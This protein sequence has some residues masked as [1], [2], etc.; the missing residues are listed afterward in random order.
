MHIYDISLTITPRL[1]VWPGDP[2]IVLER[3]SRIEDGDNANVSR[4]AM[5]VHTGT[6]L[7]AP[8]HFLA[9]SS[10][11]VEQLD[12]EVLTGPA[13][14]IRLPDE[15]ELVTAKVLQ[16]ARIPAHTRRLLLKTRNSRFWEDP[17]AGFQTDF[18]ALRADAA[19]YLVERGIQ[20]VGVDY[21]SVAPFHDSRQTHEIL[22]RAGVIIVEGLDLRQVSAGRYQLFCLPL[23]LGG[24]D[25]AP[26]RAILVEQA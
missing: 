20:L 18:T 4:I 13:V 16:Q 8:F 14:V 2:Q 1:P 17:D 23:K 3:V 26:V 15:V 9:D 12:I 19:T 24:A 22:L 11:T 6:H 21:L 10:V 25:G 7:D 5:G